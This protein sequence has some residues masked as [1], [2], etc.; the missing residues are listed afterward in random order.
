MPIELKPH[1]IETYR[2]MEAKFKESKKVA[3]IQ[4]PGTGKSYLAL[5]LLEENKGKK[6]IYLAPSN[7]ILHNLK[8][9]IFESG[10]SMKDFSSLKRITYAKLM[11]MSDEEIAKLEVDIIILDEFHHCGAP[12]W[13]N[14]VSRLL[15]QNPD[16]SI[17]G[18]SATPI[19]YSDNARDMAEELFEGNVASEMNLEEAIDGGILPEATYVSALYSYSDQLNQMQQDI[20][21]I[22]NANK[23]DEAQ[24]LLLELKG[25][26][27][28]KTQHL[29]E[30]LS[31]YMTNKNGKYI[32]FCKNIEDMKQKMQTAQEMFGSVNSN[33]TTYSVSSVNDIKL[34][35]RTLNAFEQADD[36]TLKLMFA[37]DML[38]EGYHITDLDGVVMMR[39]TFSPTIFE[40]QLGRALSVKKDGGTPP[41]V[42]DLVNNFDSCKI[43]ED[44]C[45]KI[46]QYGKGDGKKDSETQKNMLAIFDKTKEFRDIASKIAELCKR[47]I[48]TDEKIEIFNKFMETG[49]ELTGQTVF[50]GYPI[51]LWGIQIRNELKNQ[52]GKFT[53]IQ[54]EKLERIGVLE[55][56]IDAT[57]DEKIQE[58]VDWSIQ[59]PMI[60]IVNCPMK[61]L[62]YYAQSEEELEE[63]KK[64]YE[65]MQG[66][67]K[68]VRVRKSEREINIRTRNCV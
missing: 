25:K 12:E 39:P 9:N 7:S 49:E 33:I 15:E 30:L 50:E 62:S 26:L 53:E 17:L 52:R 51:G 2:K 13:G 29:S 55:R 34:N 10:M 1:N 44:F 47:N 27:D 3:V 21:K 40:Q 35:D 4:P 31:Q 6:T 45:E 60:K 20:S 61:I 63:L 59:Y 57:V 64:Q 8:K 42:L 28:E 16:A 38:N 32:V 43:I 22:P 58:L 14:G 68:Y 18:L 67:Y 36:D 65:R 37:V 5:K 66:Y 24:K 48:T 23:R 54:L 41:V 11:K 19:R 46:R 56:Q